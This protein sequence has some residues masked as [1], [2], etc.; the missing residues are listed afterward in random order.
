MRVFV[1]GSKPLLR[2]NVV[3]WKGIY[4]LQKSSWIERLPSMF[5][6][7]FWGVYSSRKGPCRCNFYF[8]FSFSV[9]TSLFFALPYHYIPS[10]GDVW[11]MDMFPHEI[12]FL[13]VGDAYLKAAIY[14]GIGLFTSPWEFYLVQCNQSACFRSDFA[15]SH[16]FLPE[17]HGNLESVPNPPPKC[18]EISPQE[19][20]G[21][22]FFQ[23]NK[24]GGGSNSH[25]FC[26]F[27]G[28]EWKWSPTT[29]EP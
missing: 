2:S 29:L 22:Y 4:L 19:R 9:F 14:R 20:A 7:T 18:H 27:H 1:H 23:G 26:H 25:F 28:H 8:F 12:H 24:R 6:K 3:I 10:K 5:P 16:P 21:V 11:A 13:N 15:R 17:T